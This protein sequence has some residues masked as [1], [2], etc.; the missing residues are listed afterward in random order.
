MKRFISLSGGVEST[1]MCVLYGKGATTTSNIRLHSLALSFRKDLASW[2]ALA[3]IIVWSKQ[4]AAA[5]IK[6]KA[7]A[8]K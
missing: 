4:E 7:L 1:T 2:V 5:L 3:S 8:K 6:C